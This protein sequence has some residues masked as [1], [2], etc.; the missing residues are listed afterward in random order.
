MKLRTTFKF[1]DRRVQNIRPEQKTKTY[2]DQSF[3]PL[4]LVITACGTKTYYARFQ[5]N[6]Q[7]YNFKLGRADRLSV[8]EARAR[9]VNFINH[10]TGKQ[11]HVQSSLTVDDIFSLYR[12]NELANRRT[13]AGRKH[14]LE[15]SYDR[16]VKPRIGK[17]LVDEITKKSVRQVFKDLSE[18][19]YCVHNRSLTAVKS[20]FNYVIQYE[21]E[22]DVSSNPFVAVNKMPDV[23][24]NRYLTK[25]EAKR[26]LD[27]L[28][29]EP[30][31]NMADVYRMALF[32]GARLSNVRMMRWEEVDLMGGRWLIPA[33]N[34][35]T[36]QVYQIPLHQHVIG[37]LERRRKADSGA[38]FVFASSRSKYGYITGGDSVWKSAIQ[39]AGLYHTNPDIRPRPHDLRRTFATW[40]IQSGADISVVSK[41]LCHTSLKHTM[42]YAHTNIDQVR[43][44]INGAFDFL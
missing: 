8:D 10:E 11:K 23:Q 13:I 24:R 2:S 38:G 26:L 19:G 21:D 25:A 36:R 20:A 27:A 5:S 40:Q 31:Q 30:N 4:K 9:A 28:A 37:L 15:V 12:D 16:H 7:P 44:A 14:G 33:T 3:T 34:T 35:K 29:V 41:A 18:L 39:R 22:L 32:T 1:T 6:G 42:I 17:W 43:N